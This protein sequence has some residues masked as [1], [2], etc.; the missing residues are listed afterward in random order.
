MSSPEVV[1]RARSLN[2]SKRVGKYYVG[3]T[4]GEASGLGGAAGRGQ[5]CG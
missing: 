5:R 1:R 3:R 2:L 4:I